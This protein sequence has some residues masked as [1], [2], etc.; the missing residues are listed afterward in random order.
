MTRIALA[1]ALVLALA[2]C[3]RQ[4]PSAAATGS[5]APPAS[6]SASTPASAPA[7]AAESRYIPFTKC[8]LVETKE[9]EDWSISKCEALPGYQVFIDY[10]D[11]R[12][13]LRLV[14]RGGKEVNL[15]LPYIGGGGFNALGPTFEWR[16]KTTGGTF[17]PHALIVRNAKSE[18][19]EHSERQTSLLA[20]IDLAKLCVVA[21]VRPGPDQNQRAQEIA[22]AGTQA[23]LPRPG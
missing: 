12:D 23:C 10:G 2:A 3:S 9:D 1:A 8:K 4:Q 21:L 7:P 20:V 17:T 16:G 18:D 13:D 22:D 5:A 15:G 14:P 11:A 6:G 19:P